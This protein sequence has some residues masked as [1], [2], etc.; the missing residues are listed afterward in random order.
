MPAHW[1]TYWSDSAEVSGRA[2][3]RWNAASSDHAVAACDHASSD[4]SEP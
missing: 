4:G 1:R 3:K 2:A